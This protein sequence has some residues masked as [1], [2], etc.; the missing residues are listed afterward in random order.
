VSL[1]LLK[2]IF[3][4]FK[5][6]LLSKRES[7]IPCR[8]LL[9]AVMSGRIT[10]RLPLPGCKEQPYPIKNSEACGMHCSVTKKQNTTDVYLRNFVDNRT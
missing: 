3:D 4:S 8:T 5:I 2:D 9:Q 7:L 10:Q 1:G 6:S